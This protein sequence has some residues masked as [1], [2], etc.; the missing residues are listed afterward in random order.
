MTSNQRIILGLHRL[1]PCVL[2]PTTRLLL[3]DFCGAFCGATLSRNKVAP[4]ITTPNTT[5]GAANISL[6]LSLKT[7][8][9][10]LVWNQKPVSNRS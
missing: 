2:A 9:K 5:K 6:Y 1:R 7:K 10:T 8:F 3:R 4:V